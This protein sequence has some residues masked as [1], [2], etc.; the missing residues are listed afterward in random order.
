MDKNKIFLINR[1]ELDGRLDSYYYNEV[2]LNNEINL[3]KIGYTRFGEFIK[4][5]TKGSTP[6][7]INEGIPFLKVLNMN[8]FGIKTE[9]LDFIS[10]K[11]HESMKRSQ[12]HGDEILYSMAGTIG[13][14]VIYDKKFEQA[15][16]NQAIAK[17][18]LKDER[19]NILMVY[20]LNSK[21]CN[22]QAKRFLTV[23]AQPNINFE[24][25]KSIKIP[26]I[27]EKQKIDII[28]TMNKAYESKKQKEKQAQELIDNIDYYIFHKLEIKLPVEPENNI[29]N[30][31]F[32]VGFDDIFT[33]RLDADSYTSYY[34]NIFEIFENS[35]CKFTTLK[36]ITK[37][38][39]TGTTPDQKLDAF[40][41]EKEIPFLRNSDIQD[42]EIIEGKFK[43]IK[44]DLEK[45]LTF[46]YK[47]EIIICIAGTIGISALNR[48]DRLAINQNV[49]SLTI[50]E[51]NININF[52]I[53]WLNTKV[54]ISL[55][56]RLASI[57]TIAYV[58]N[59]TLLRLQIP[60]PAITIQNKIADEIKQ[61]RKKAK[62][63]QEEAKLELE[64][65]KKDVERI[66]LG[67]NYE[68]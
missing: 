21:L 50:D 62:Q 61:R 67:N 18:V 28:N 46:S 27:S 26:K 48:F 35:S 56:K 10:L 29:E 59:P 15:N 20:L 1:G 44:N 25:I 57:A 41:S 45:N 60:L 5:I 54:A 7:M 49:S 34:Q 63:L 52:L 19:L 33:D 8:E 3:H 40:T 38:I 31:T 6:E 65:A 42:G 24:Q 13:I 64:N 4:I 43:Y 66:I 17:I 53:Y 36:A 58:N 12:L 37:K 47:N 9:K 68:C 22:L 23:S 51:T 39:K 11:T 2:F 32:K 14:A 16:I 30:R 55:L